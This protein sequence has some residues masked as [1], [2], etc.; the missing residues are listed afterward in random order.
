MLRAARQCF[1]ESGYART[2]MADIAQAAGVTPRAIYYYFPSKADLFEQASV[3]AYQRFG[4]E[5][6]LRVLAH[7]HTRARLHGFVDVFRVLFREDPSL[8]AFIS[9]ARL[10]AHRNPELP[11]SRQL[12]GEFPDVNELLVRDAVTQGALADDIDTGGAVALLEVFGA[13]LTLLATGE[14]Q[15]DYLSMLD[16][17]DR[18]IDGALFTD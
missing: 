18:F 11:S 8:V 16:V 17:V 2:S 15:D 14:R 7:D 10:E 4:E 13:G 1:G 3:A 12:V 5:I 9:L 6:A